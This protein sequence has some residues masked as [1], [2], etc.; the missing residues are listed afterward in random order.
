MSEGRE[1]S[2]ESTKLD[3]PREEIMTIQPHQ[4]LASTSRVFF[5]GLKMAKSAI[6]WQS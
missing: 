5:L 3:F 4:V 2:I 1:Y 6:S